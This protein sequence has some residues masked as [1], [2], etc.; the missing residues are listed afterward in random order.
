MAK[1]SAMTWE[2]G[3]KVVAGYGTTIPAAL[4]DAAETEARR[5]LG[6]TKADILRLGGFPAAH[7]A[8][9]LSVVKDGDEWDLRI[10]GGQGSGGGMGTFGMG[11]H[12]IGWMWLGEFGYDQF[13]EMADDLEWAGDAMAKGMG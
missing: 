8:N 2:E 1:T 10:G 3:A 4:E 5:M 6:P 11:R 13:D 9:T 7:M 12:D